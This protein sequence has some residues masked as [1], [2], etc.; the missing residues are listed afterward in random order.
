MKK[1]SLFLVYLLFVSPL[2]CKDV[3]S[4]YYFSAENIP[5]DYNDSEENVDFDK[6]LRPDFDPDDPEVLKPR[7]KRPVDYIPPILK[8][9]GFAVFKKY[10]LFHNEVKKKI[11]SLWEY[12]FNKQSDAE[13]TQ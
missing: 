5:Y 1:S 7:Q 9:M 3:S 10:V 2:V 6:L 13:T 12:L 8:T 4:T 11:I